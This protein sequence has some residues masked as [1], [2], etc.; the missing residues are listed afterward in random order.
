MDTRQFVEGYRNPAYHLISGKLA[1][2]EYAKRDTEKIQHTREDSEVRTLMEGPRKWTSFFDRQLILHLRGEKTSANEP[3]VLLDALQ[4][5]Q[6]NWLN[7]HLDKSVAKSRELAESKNK[8]PVVNELTFHMLNREMM[9]LWY[10]LLL[11]PEAV[12]LTPAHL[13]TMQTRLALTASSLYSDAQRYRLAEGKDEM[14]YR[15]GL[16]VSSQLSEFDT[17]IVLLEI[18]KRQGSEN[19]SDFIAV[20]ASPR[21]EAAYGSGARLSDFLFFDTLTSQVRGVQTKS[22]IDGQFIKYD[23][24]YV[25]V[26]DGV[27][28][29]GNSHVEYSKK[30]GVHAAPDP[31]LISLDFLKNQVSIKEL[32]RNP[33]FNDDMRGVLVARQKAQHILGSRKSYYHQAV[34]HVG[35][36]LLYDLYKQKTSE[37]TSEVS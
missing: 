11:G 18:M 28:D 23:Q 33:I 8:D 6:F 7:V 12:V 30:Y 3:D 29:L 35:E 24:D 26:V 32:S 14:K 36:R 25:T 16:Q 19:P 17:A 2:E 15:V 34:Q 37:N 22:K 27:T 21:F 9:P 4:D 13:H 10:S 20:P 5:Y 31:G 1:E